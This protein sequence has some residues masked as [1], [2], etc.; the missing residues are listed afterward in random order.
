[1]KLI[2][3]LLC[4]VALTSPTTGQESIDLLLGF[5]IG[6]LT[7]SFD[8]STWYSFSVGAMKRDAGFIASASY[9]NAVTHSVALSPQILFRFIDRLFV[10][11]GPEVEIRSLEPAT[12]GLNGNF[13]YSLSDAFYLS[14]GYSKVEALRIGIMLGI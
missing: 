5:G 7:G 14:A 1:M 4:L 13:H 10:S 9:S 2:A 8:Q 11:I 3:T 12:I 6:G